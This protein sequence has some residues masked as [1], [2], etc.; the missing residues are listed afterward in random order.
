[1]EYD[2]V[3]VVVEKDY[4]FHLLQ[5]HWNWNLMDQ[6][7]EVVQLVQLVVLEILEQV[8]VMAF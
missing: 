4:D 5:S 1:M 8:L 3:A 2:M 6:N 7:Q